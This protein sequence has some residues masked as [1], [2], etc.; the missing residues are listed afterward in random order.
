MFKHY[1]FKEVTS[2]D[3]NNAILYEVQGRM[4][5]SGLRVETLNTLCNSIRKGIGTSFKYS[6]HS[7]E[8]AK[9][10]EATILHLQFP[11]GCSPSW[12]A[13]RVIQAQMN[14]FS[15]EMKLI[16]AKEKS[17]KLNDI[18]CKTINGQPDYQDWDALSPDLINS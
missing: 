10:K 4:K 16:E 7:E 17:H 6:V 11:A 1:G 13:W 5:Y 9:G 18:L 3:S 2:L 8:T 12:D 14:V 15:K